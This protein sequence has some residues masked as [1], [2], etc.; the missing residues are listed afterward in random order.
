MSEKIARYMK[1]ENILG[2][3]VKLCIQ[4]EG[5]GKAAEIYAQSL[6]QKILIHSTKGVMAGL[7]SQCEFSFGLKFFPLFRQF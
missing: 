7:I 2:I 3:S 5:I 1:Y 4:Y 6:C